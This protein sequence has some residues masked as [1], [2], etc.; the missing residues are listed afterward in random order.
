MGL[1]EDCE[2]FFKTSD[3]Y[4]ILGL[5]SENKDTLTTQDI[6]KG[7]YKKSLLY[8]PDKFLNSDEKD[9][10]E[11]TSKFQIISKIWS[12][13]GNEEERKIYDETGGVGEDEDLK[14]WYEVWRKQFKPVTL[15]DIEEFLKTYTNSKEEEEDLIK[16]YE[17][18]KGDLYK[19]L[20]YV[21]NYDVDNVGDL[22][23]RINQ[24]IDDKKIEKYPKWKPLTK[25]QIKK[26]KSR[27]EREAEES[28]LAL[29]DLLK[30]EEGSNLEEMILARGRKRDS[31]FLK[32][33]EDK[34]C[35]PKTKKKKRT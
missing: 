5:D 1:K 34:Y 28:G 2:K 16:A 31:D 9:K 3:L 25:A 22:M 21:Y 17:K 30:N 23:N 8:H 20:E 27:K 15:K 19:M 18:C 26:L 35:Q 14:D 29:K 11:A 12:I 32:A 10:C 33:I 24:M 4:T 7:Y 6:K 13:L